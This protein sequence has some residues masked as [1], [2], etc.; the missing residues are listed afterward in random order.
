MRYTLITGA[1]LIAAGVALSAVP[2]EAQTSFDCAKAQSVSEKE[3]CRV[4]DLQWFDRQLGR[5]YGE[6]KAKG[7][8][9]VVADQRAFLARREACGAKFEC[10][11]KAYGDRLKALGKLSDIED[12]AAEFRPTAFGGSLWVVRYGS[13]GAIKILTVGDGGHTC[14]FETDNA[15]QT[16]KGVLEA[17]EADDETTTC[18]LN[19]I[20]DKD[21]VRVE[22]H[23]CQ[24]FCGVRAVMDGPYRR[25]N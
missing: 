16:G 22:T 9:T 21:N 8:P 25:V 18:R 14:V 15:T 17:V 19:V 20:P 11:E 12:P 13:T 5:L 24:S 23:D 3:V 4:P 7:G 10:L 2:V 6:V 1:G